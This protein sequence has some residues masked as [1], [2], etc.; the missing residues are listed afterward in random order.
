MDRDSQEVRANSRS[1]PPG[2]LTGSALLDREGSSRR[3]DALTLVCLIVCAYCAGYGLTD[4]A[5]ASRDKAAASARAE[6]EAI[7]RH[8]S[9]APASTGARIVAPPPEPAHVASVTSPAPSVPAKNISPQTQK[10]RRPAPALPEAPQP[11]IRD[12]PTPQ[13]SIEEV[14]QALAL[15]DA[16]QRIFASVDEASPK[17]LTITPPPAATAHNRKSPRTIRVATLEAL[18]VNGALPTKIVKRGVQRLLPQYNRCAELTNQP[19]RLKLSTTIDEAGRGRRITVDGSS[20]P[21]LR[22]CLEQATTRLVVPAP[23]TGTAR[24]HWVLQLAAH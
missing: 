4:W 7:V 5:C 2:F 3:R 9:R 10:R 20:N 15:A 11:V 17:P 12:E 24:A 6:A 18:S 19:Q 23:D 1:W 21:N 14:N 22:H 16:S 13:L 8:R